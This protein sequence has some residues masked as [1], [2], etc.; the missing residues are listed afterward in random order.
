M[1][2]QSVGSSPS[3]S[4]VQSYQQKPAQNDQSS[5]LQG[6]EKSQATKSAS[7]PKAPSKTE[8]LMTQNKQHNVAQAAATQAANSVPGNNLPPASTFSTYVWF[9]LKGARSWECFYRGAKTYHGHFLP[10]ILK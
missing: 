4:Q 3:Y 7:T 2:I 5:E 1:S 10:Y 9:W 6:V 8:E